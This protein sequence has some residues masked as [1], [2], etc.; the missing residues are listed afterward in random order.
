MNYFDHASERL[1]Y[2]KLAETDVTSWLE[3]FENNDTLHFLGMDTSRSHLDLATEWIQKQ[4]ERYAASGLGHLAVIEK[5]TDKLVGFSGIIPRDLN[6]KPYFEIGYSFKPTSWGKGFASEASQHLKKIG[7]ELEISDKF[8]SIIHT[9]NLPSMKVA[10][11]NGMV[12]LFETK[13]TG[14]DVVVYGDK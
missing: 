2:R 3:F 14:I 13:Y 10:K 7:L 1:S 11:K 8:V 9:E 5:S 12:P 6:S 4:I